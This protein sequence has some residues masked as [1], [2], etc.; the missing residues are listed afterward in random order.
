MDASKRVHIEK[1]HN[2]F[3]QYRDPQSRE[4]RKLSANQFMEVW[5]HYDK[6]ANGYIE[7][8]ELDGFLREFV[9]SANASDVSPE[10]SMEWQSVGI[11]LDWVKQ[12]S[13]KASELIVARW[14]VFDLPSFR[15]QHH[16]GP[17]SGNPVA[18]KVILNLLSHST[19]THRCHLGGAEGLL[20]GG[21]RWQPGWQNW[22]PR[23]ERDWAEKKGI[24]PR[25]SEWEEK[26]LVRVIQ[27]KMGHVRSVTYHAL[28]W[29]I[30]HR[31]L[32]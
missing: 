19:D 5:S 27:P 16:F 24:G 4:L 17:S 8:T 6:D 18:A 21:V 28:E 26:L 30:I 10:V 20:H 13:R 31:G 9:S 12:M 2:F 32:S 22:Y 14:H 11:G 23:G 7:G 15:S 1:A 3:R 25:G 29:S